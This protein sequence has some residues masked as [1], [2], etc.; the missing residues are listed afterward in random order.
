MAGRSYPRVAI[1]PTSPRRVVW[2]LPQY[3]STLSVADI[4][5]YG[6]SELCDCSSI[7]ITCE[8]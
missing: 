3:Y 8:R 4:D 1:P 6:K 7:V 2:N 5:A